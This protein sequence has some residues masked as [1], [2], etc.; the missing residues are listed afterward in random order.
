M[1]V[2]PKAKSIPKKAK[3]VQKPDTVFNVSARI[4]PADKHPLGKAELPEA[5]RQRSSFPPI[6]PGF[7]GKEGG[8]RFHGTRSSSTPKPQWHKGGFC[9]FFKLPTP[10]VQ[11]IPPNE[12]G[13]RPLGFCECG[14]WTVPKAGSPPCKVRPRVLHLFSGPHVREDGLGA[15][16]NKFG[17]STCDVDLVNGD[18]LL[19]RNS[20]GIESLSDDLCNGVFDAAFLGTPC[21][22]FSNLRNEDDGGPR[23]L[24]DLDNIL[25]IPG[26]R[27][28]E[29]RQIRDANDLVHFSATVCR[30]M[31][32]LGRPFIL[33]NPRP[34]QG[35]ATLFAFPDIVDLLQAPGVETV[36]FDQC[37]FGAETTKPTRL[38]FFKVNL[39]PM[40]KFKCNHPIQRWKRTL[41]DGS[42]EVYM[43]PHE[44]LVG[45]WR[46]NPVT[47]KRERASKALAAYPGEL[48]CYFAECI[49]KC[50]PCLQTLKTEVI[51]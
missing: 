23:P 22:T 21:E 28:S 34:W 8:G 42:I 19:S 37:M 18:D 51:P 49:S 31:Y 13:E 39:K 27:G 2:S 48:N 43:A 40:V 3:P 7:P 29:F 35:K 6:P 33:E 17:W 45:R 30:I 4:A 20:N 14:K 1:R 10:A 15:W 9:R 44:S 12:R 38:L 26:L 16:L 47:G 11:P 41:K 25:G 32:L 24:R 5:K 50:K 36:D 46:D